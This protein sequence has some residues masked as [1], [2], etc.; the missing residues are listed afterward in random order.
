MRNGQMDR[1]LKCGDNYVISLCLSISNM[2][3]PSSEY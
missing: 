1:S 3:R 2:Q